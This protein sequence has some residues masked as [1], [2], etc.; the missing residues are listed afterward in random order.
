MSATCSHLG[1]IELT[2]LPAARDTRSPAPP[3]PASWCY[4]D[5]VAF[6]VSRP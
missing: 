3:N 4:V 1:S 6:V 2:E 5:E